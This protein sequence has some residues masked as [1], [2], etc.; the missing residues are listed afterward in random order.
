MVAVSQTPHEVLNVQSLV[1]LYRNAQL[2]DFSHLLSTHPTTGVVSCAKEA[3]RQRI[4]YRAT[5]CWRL[6]MG[7]A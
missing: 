6:R 5:A 2:R 7:Y 1:R 3:E 4:V